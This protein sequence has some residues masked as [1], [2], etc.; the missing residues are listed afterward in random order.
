LC[1]T[2]SSVFLIGYVILAVSA[3]LVFATDV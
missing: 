1:G 2:S 3:D